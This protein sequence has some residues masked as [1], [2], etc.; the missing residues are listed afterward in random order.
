[1][2][3]RQNENQAQSAS[4]SWK[5]IRIALPM[6]LLLAICTAATA[7]FPKSAKLA[8]ASAVAPALRTNV[9]N[10]PAVTA[11]D[12]GPRPLPANS[13]SFL[14]ALSGNEQQIEPNLTTEFNRVHDVVVTSPT[15]GGLGPR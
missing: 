1:M 3:S 12:P 8:K 4:Q 13:G 2:S 6:V 9:V 11:V 14:P 5:W 15:D 7:Y 10:P